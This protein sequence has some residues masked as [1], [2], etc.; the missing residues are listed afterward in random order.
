MISPE[1]IERALTTAQDACPCW[2]DGENGPESCGIGNVRCELHNNIAHKFAAEFARVEAETVER[3][4]KIADERARD[5]NEKY[6][7]LRAFCSRPDDT[8]VL[9]LAAYAGEAER[10][11]AAIRAEGSQP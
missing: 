1:H 7:Q 10:I 11:A 9:K 3:C 8:G 6:E 5:M 2:G 4:A